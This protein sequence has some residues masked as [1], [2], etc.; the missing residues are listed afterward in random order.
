MVLAC[1]RDFCYVLHSSAFVNGTNENQFKWM[2]VK[3]IGGKP[4]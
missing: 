1:G 4:G 2:Q 3:S